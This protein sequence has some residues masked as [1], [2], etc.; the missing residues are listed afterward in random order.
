MVLGVAHDTPPPVSDVSVSTDED[1]A[2]AG[3]EGL[4]VEELLDGILV[5]DEVH[6]EYIYELLGDMQ[7]SR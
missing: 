4:N 5:A 3:W 2:D 7:M 6:N 1:P